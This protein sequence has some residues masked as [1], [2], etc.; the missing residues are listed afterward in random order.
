MKSRILLF[1]NTDYG[2]AGH[3]SNQDEAGASE[4]HVSR[5]PDT[6]ISEDAS[7]IA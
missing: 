5:I 7:H 6:A 3:L 4:K 2:H 1:Q